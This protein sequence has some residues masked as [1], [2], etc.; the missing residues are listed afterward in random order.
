MIDANDRFR[1]N[2]G[3]VEDTRPANESQ[4]TTGVPVTPVSKL[5]VTNVSIGSL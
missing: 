2:R 4:V 1:A 3:A 5:Q